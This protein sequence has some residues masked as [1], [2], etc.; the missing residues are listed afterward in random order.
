MFAQWLVVKVRGCD[1]RGLGLRGL[2]RALQTPCLDRGGEAPRGNLPEGAQLV[3]EGHCVP[4][5]GALDLLGQDPV[6]VV[7][8]VWVWPPV[9]VASSGRGLPVGE[10]LCGRGISWTGLPV[11]VLPLGV[12]SRGRGPIGE[13]AHGCG[14]IGRGYHGRGLIGRPRPLFP[15]RIPGRVPCGCPFPAHRE[16]RQRTGG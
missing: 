16:D 1:L 2:L 6:G 3:H 10:A 9:G 4:Y 12:V 11:G 7:P 13:A 8:T 14:P 15:G 5:P